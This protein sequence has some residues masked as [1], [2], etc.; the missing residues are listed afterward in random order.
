MNKIKSNFMS[1]ATVMVITLLGCMN[2][3]V[4]D[5]N[6]VKSPLEL[7]SDAT[8]APAE[9]TIQ[10][11]IANTRTDIPTNKIGTQEGNTTPEFTLRMSDGGTRIF[12]ASL[13]RDDPV[14]LLFFTPH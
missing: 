1:L 10:P 4:S 14:F 2:S 8:T 12:P 9:I 3:P 5:P 7:T 6:R 13:K 11:T